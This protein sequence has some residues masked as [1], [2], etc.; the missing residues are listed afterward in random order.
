LCPHRQDYGIN[1]VSVHSGRESLAVLLLNFQAFNRDRV[2]F[3]SRGERSQLSSENDVTFASI[4]PDNRK[5]LYVRNDRG[6]VRFMVP[7]LCPPQ[8]RNRTT[9]QMLMNGAPS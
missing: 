1:F 6:Q 4:S 5:L 8:D 3:D 2:L 7:L 9:C